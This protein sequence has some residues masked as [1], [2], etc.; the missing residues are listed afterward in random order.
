[1]NSCRKDCWNSMNSISIYGPRK[2]ESKLNT[3]RYFLS[4]VWW[5]VFA[6][7][8]FSLEGFL[9]PNSSFPISL[10]SGFLEWG[11]NGGTSPFLPD[12]GIR[13]APDICEGVYVTLSLGSYS[14]NNYSIH[15]SQPGIKWGPWHSQDCPFYHRTNCFPKTVVTCLPH[16]LTL[17]TGLDPKASALSAHPG[18]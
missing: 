6:D 14:V 7:W 13:L 17:G 11:R 15:L 4:C 1:M 10:G 5:I 16:M 9:G 18:C 8:F 12:F 2:Q 3:F